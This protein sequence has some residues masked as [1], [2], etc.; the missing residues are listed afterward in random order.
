MFALVVFLLIQFCYKVF[1]C[2]L[3]FVY[4]FESVAILFN[5]LVFTQAVR[6]GLLV[7]FMQ[8]E[9]LLLGRA[10]LLLKPFNL[11]AKVLG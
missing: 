6:F 3:T 4:A 8:L 7:F 5:N 11:T 10:L 1:I 2:S 9:N